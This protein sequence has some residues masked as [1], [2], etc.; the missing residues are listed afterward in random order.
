MWILRVN[1]VL[2]NRPL[3]FRLPDCKHTDL[4]QAKSP[5][6]WRCLQTQR[7]KQLNRVSPHNL[8]HFSH[9]KGFSEF[10][11]MQASSAVTFSTSLVMFTSS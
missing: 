7:L 8:L 1:I 5:K 2:L 9:E 3:A 6:G 4:Q 10:T 11:P